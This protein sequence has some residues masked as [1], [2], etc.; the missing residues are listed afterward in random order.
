MTAIKRRPITAPTEPASM[1]D[2]VLIGT[3]AIADFI[4]I[5]ERKCFHWLANGYIP[6]SKTGNLW[7]AT[8]SQL[9]RHFDGK[10][11]AS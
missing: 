3:R 7:T 8:R 9:R 2:D 4:G 11:E 10:R 5:D 6:A 1:A